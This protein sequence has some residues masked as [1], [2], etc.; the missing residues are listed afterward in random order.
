MQIVICNDA[1]R[2]DF[3]GACKQS[4]NEM[5]NRMSSAQVTLKQV[6]DTAVASQVI[7]ANGFLPIFDRFAQLFYSSVY[8]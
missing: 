6:T 5:R 7:Y 8:L 1:T 2:G 4:E 3:G